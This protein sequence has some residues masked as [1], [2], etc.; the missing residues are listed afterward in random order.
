MFVDVSQRGA[1]FCS[2]PPFP[3]TNW[4]S[5]FTSP[6]II[7]IFLLPPSGSSRE[8][9]PRISLAIYP[10]SLFIL[11]SAGI[12]FL[13]GWCS[14]PLLQPLIRLETRLEP[15]KNE[16]GEYPNV[17]TDFFYYLFT[18]S[19]HESHCPEPMIKWIS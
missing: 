6:G 15:H 8:T 17:L 12:R 1:F 3:G 2:V 16:N 10:A 14:P 11:L 4:Y 5:V 19:T 18:V 7:P 9:W 13:Y